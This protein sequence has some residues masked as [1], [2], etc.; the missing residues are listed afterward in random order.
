MEWLCDSGRRSII[1]VYLARG[2]GGIQVRHGGSV[3]WRYFRGCDTEK[4]RFSFAASVIRLAEIDGQKI[5]GGFRRNGHF[6]RPGSAEPGLPL[7]H[8][9]AHVELRLTAIFVAR[10]MALRERSLR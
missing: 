6:W 5:V 2:G 10:V 7:R 8:T 3:G 1:R 9:P 4:D